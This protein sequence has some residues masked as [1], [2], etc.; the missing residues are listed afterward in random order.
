LAFQSITACTDNEKLGE[1]EQEQTL[2]SPI[3]THRISLFNRSLPLA[4]LHCYS[5]EN[6]GGHNDINIGIIRHKADQ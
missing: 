1:E 5:L 4:A 2:C 6:N 3:C